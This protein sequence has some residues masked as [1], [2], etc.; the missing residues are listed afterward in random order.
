LFE[1]VDNRVVIDFI[2]DICCYSFIYGPQSITLTM[3]NT[4][5]DS[6]RDSKAAR[7]KLSQDSVNT[8][9]K[10]TGNIII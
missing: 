3:S 1:S 6:R 7:N 10:A 4:A 2:K 8:A 9:L 5:K